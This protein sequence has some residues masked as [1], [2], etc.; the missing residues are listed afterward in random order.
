[1]DTFNAADL[2]EL[3]LKRDQN[4]VSIY[5]PTHRMGPET[6]QDPIRL[7]N[8]LKK[9]EELMGDL[10][11]KNSDARGPLKPAYDLLADNRYWSYQDEGLAIFSAPSY[12]KT[13]K[14]PFK[15]NELVVVLDRFHLKPLMPLLRDRGSFYVLALSQKNVRLFKGDKLTMKEIELDG[16]VTSIDETLKYD[17]FQKQTSW[18]GQRSAQ[19]RKREGGIMH[20]HGAGADESN[21]EVLRFLRDVDRGLKNIIGNDNIPLTLACVESLPPIY[22][23]ANT[24]PHLLDEW[25]SGNPD[26]LTPNEI[27][28][29]AWKLIEPHFRKA[30]AEAM[31][32]FSALTG[33][34]KTSSDLNKV[35]EAAINGRVDT[36]FVALGIQRW[37][38]YNSEK[39]AVEGHSERMPGDEDLLDLAAIQTFLNGGA[40]YAVDLDSVP[41]DRNIAAIF[42]Y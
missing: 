13:L 6:Q 19:V 32:K 17:E 3:M 38:V 14:L 5:L 40:V 12:F 26:N 30:E 42:R 41:G 21:N 31:A 37:G 25:I 23:S 18:H 29:Q 2:Q 34:G 24:Y 16:M 11:V 4:C 7:K 33:T 22:K 28:E 15:C 39:N 20:G 8:L 27:H 10:G 1:M 36:L 9:A 35:V